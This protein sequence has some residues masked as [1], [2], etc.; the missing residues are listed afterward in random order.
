MFILSPAE[1]PLHDTEVTECYQGDT[2]VVRADGDA[3]VGDEVSHESLDAVP[4]GIINATRTIHHKH[5][6]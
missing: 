5:Q 4:T 3:R 2:C 1:I 6:V